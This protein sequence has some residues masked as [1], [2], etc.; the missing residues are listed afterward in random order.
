MG[1]E[2]VEWNH[3]ARDVEDVADKDT[4]AIHGKNC[5]AGTKHRKVGVVAHSD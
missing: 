3:Q 1:A 4:F 2:A 5:C